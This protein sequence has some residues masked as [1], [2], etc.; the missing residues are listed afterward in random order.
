MCTHKQHKSNLRSDPVKSNDSQDGNTL[1]IMYSAT[2]VYSK[3]AQFN[4]R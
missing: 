4:G 2:E 1:R 3:G